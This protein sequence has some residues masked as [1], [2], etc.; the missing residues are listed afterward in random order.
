MPPMPTTGIIWSPDVSSCCHEVLDLFV[1]RVR[2][3]EELH[4]DSGLSAQVRFLYLVILQVRPETMTQLAQAAHFTRSYTAKLCKN[5]QDRGWCK[6][7]RTRSGIS[8]V[9]QMPVAAEQRLVAELKMLRPYAPHLGEFIMKTELNFLIRSD[10]YVDN[11]RPDFL[12]FPETGVRLEYD[13]YYP[14]SNWL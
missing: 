14:L 10:C 5:L 3:P 2:I 1:E 12:K 13:R 8:I 11:A 4:R 7:H 6:I 9:P